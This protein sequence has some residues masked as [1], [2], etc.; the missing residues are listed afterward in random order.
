ME[1]RVEKS[2]REDVFLVA[3]KMR[4]IDRLEIFLMNRSSPLKSL[5][6][7]FEQSE[8]CFTIFVDDEAVA[9]F[10]AS[11]LSLLSDEGVV[12][13]LGTKAFGK[14]KKTFVVQSKKWLDEL[15][16]TGVDVLF[17]YVWQKNKLSIRWLK[18]LGFVFEEPIEVGFRKHKFVRFSKRR[19]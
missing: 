18:S 4:R 14:I 10:G 19:K 5:M 6:T 8:K 13:L 2:K 16:E 17:N 1:A 11:K 15:F 9:M 7:G 12:W 3:E